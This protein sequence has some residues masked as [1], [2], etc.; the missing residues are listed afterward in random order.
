ME[1]CN[2]FGRSSVGADLRLGLDRGGLVADMTPE[3]KAVLNN[4][5][6]VLEKVQLNVGERVMFM[7][8]ADYMEEMIDMLVNHSCGYKIG[9]P[10]E[11][12]PCKVCK[13]V[14]LHS[15]TK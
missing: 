5:I 13:W 6:G 14:S 9:S 10:M 1:T 7:R 12:T 11:T 8:V 2:G 15:R 4:I 3:G